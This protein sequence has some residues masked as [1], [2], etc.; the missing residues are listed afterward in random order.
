MAQ[1]NGYESQMA[2]N[3][4]GIIQQKWTERYGLA[5]TTLPTQEIQAD[6]LRVAQD[7]RHSQ[8]KVSL[9]GTIDT[10]RGILES[11]A[12]EVEGL[13]TQLAA[14]QT[15]EANLQAQLAAAQAAVEQPTSIHITALGMT[16]GVDES[17]GTTVDFNSNGPGF[18]QAPNDGVRVA[19]DPASGFYLYRY[20]DEPDGDYFYREVGGHVDRSARRSAIYRRRRGR[21][22]LRLAGRPRTIRKHVVLSRYSGNPG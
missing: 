8:G 4:A 19:Q 13:R 20:N 11:R 9:G 5:D 22:L 14:L 1:L 10:F 16:G 2:V 12:A 21:H 7:L 18:T 3:L 17:K 15:E 6:I